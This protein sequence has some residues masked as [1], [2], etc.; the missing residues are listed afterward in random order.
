MIDRG[1]KG[2]SVF[3]PERFC[4]FKIPSVE[5]Q[6]IASQRIIINKIELADGETLARIRKKIRQLNPHALQMLQS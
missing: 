3:A 4:E 1:E 2:R 5:E 6:V